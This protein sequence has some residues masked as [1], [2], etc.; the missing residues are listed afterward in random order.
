[1]TADVI[2]LAA[3]RARRAEKAAAREAAFA[4]CIAKA[5]PQAV[6]SSR[7]PLEPVGAEPFVEPPAAEPEEPEPLVWRTSSRGNFWTRIGRAHIVIFPSRLAERQWCLRLEY[8]GRGARFL[9]QTWPSAEEGQ[10]W[11]E[12]NAHTVS[13]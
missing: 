11:V 6:A 7:A 2:N 9:K 5:Q 8:D 12:E 10:R 3:F 1:M 13:R 4:E